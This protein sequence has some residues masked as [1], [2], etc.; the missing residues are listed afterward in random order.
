MTKA[1]LALALV[2]VFVLEAAA[3][4]EPAFSLEV[5]DFLVTGPVK[6]KA[7]TTDPRVASVDWKFQGKS[8]TTP[9]PFELTVDVASS[10]V[11]RGY[12]L[13]H[14]DPALLAYLNYYAESGF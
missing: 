8:K 14:G 10:Y 4:P 5:P 9:P 3:R 7:R 2:A 13:S 1:F 11:W 6:L 12:D